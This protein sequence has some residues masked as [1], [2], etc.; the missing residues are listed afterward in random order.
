MQ[1]NTRMAAD[2]IKITLPIDQV[3][4]FLSWVSLNLIW[5]L[6]CRFRKTLK[7]IA[8]VPIREYF[9][10]GLHV[11]LSVGFFH[12]SAE[13]FDRFR[14]NVSGLMVVVE[15]SSKLAPK[16]NKHHEI[17]MEIKHHRVHKRSKIRVSFTNCPHV[18]FN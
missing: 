12:F 1:T 2:K 5:L 15:H 14:K 8:Y 6:Y 18:D 10:F 13:S 16:F 3:G 7:T 17:Y 4:N 11:P 9:A